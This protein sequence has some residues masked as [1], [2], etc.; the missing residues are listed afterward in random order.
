MACV[1]PVRRGGVDEE[2]TASSG[3]VNSYFVETDRFLYES[4]QRAG[5]PWEHKLAF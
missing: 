1:G 5:L 3:S 2:I 4:I